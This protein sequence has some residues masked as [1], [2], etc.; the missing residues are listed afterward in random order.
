MHNSLWG[1]SCSF[2]V[3]TI[4]IPHLLHFFGVEAGSGVVAALMFAVGVYG[5]G[6]AQFRVQGRPVGGAVVQALFLI[7]G[8]GVPKAVNLVPAQRRPRSLDFPLHRLLELEAE[9][10]SFS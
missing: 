6:Q 7:G 5:F 4:F 8:E 2:F 10:S 1:G 9:Q 3:F